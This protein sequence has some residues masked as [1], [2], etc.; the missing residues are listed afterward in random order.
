MAGKKWR[1]IVNPFTPGPAKTGRSET[2][3]AE[4][5]GAWLALIIG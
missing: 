3:W 2:P 5:L 4:L 1:F